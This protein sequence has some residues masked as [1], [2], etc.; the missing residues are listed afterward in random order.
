MLTS[1]LAGFLATGFIL[2]LVQYL[3]ALPWLRAA[4]AEAEGMTAG[5]R[6]LALTLVRAI[7]G[8]ALAGA[9]CGAGL[10][11]EQDADFLT[12]LGRWYGVVLYAQLLLDAVVL[13]F[14]LLLL[15]WPKGAAVAL[16]AFREG[17]R[18]PMFWFLGVFAA[19]VMLVMPFIPYFSLED[20]LKVVKELGY[21]VIMLFAAVFGVLAASISVSEEIEGR[22]AITLMSKPV[23]R[24]QFLIGKFL[25]ILMA[26]FLMAGILSVVYLLVL[27]FKPIL[28]KQEVMPPWALMRS[29]WEASW[30]DNL[31]PAGVSVVGGAVWWFYDAVVASPGLILGFCQVMVLVAVAVALATRLPMVVNLVICLMVYFLGHLSP[32]LEQVS[33]QRFAL[34]HFMAQLFNTVLPVF[35]LF[36]V[37]PALARNTLPDPQD[38]AFYIATAGGYALLYTAIALLVGLLLFEDRD[39]A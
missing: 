11:A 32:V 9:A 4:T 30:Q 28:D 6:S 14:A 24:R 22:T 17:V 36:S 23:S 12:T 35:E 2:C 16:A 10:W 20:D 39:L 37:G 26:C 25:G 21:E 1:S 34:V 3:A 38:F 33:R 5:A 7:I 18:Q 19:L 29:F 8:L 15:V 27:W 31:G 13:T